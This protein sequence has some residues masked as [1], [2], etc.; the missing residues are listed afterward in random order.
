MTAKS[1][2]EP[3]AELA[4]IAFARSVATQEGAAPADSGASPASGAASSS[5][6]MMLYL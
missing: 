1:V 5:A 2:L 4:A 3:P 6:P